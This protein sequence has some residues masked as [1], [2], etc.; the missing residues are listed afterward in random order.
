MV[1]SYHQAAVNSSLCAK[2]WPAVSLGKEAAERAF[3]QLGWIG[4]EH[5]LSLFFEPSVATSTT[6]RINKIRAVKPQALLAW[7]YSP[8]C[9][10]N[11]F[12]ISAFPLHIREAWSD[13]ARKIHTSQNNQLAAIHWTKPVPL[14][15]WGGTG[16]K[17]FPLTPGDRYFMVQTK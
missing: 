7:E 3:K 15:C 2:K 11:I 14:N 6:N 16:S 9:A 1:H 5:H 4:P 10:K 13:L 12:I 8:I 17:T